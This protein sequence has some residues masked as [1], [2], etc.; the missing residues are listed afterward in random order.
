V[1]RA[2]RIRQSES[3]GA[4]A[5]P[6]P[7]GAESGWEQACAVPIV[8]VLNETIAKL[9]E[10]GF[11]EEREQFGRKAALAKLKT[12]NER[13]NETHCDSELWLKHKHRTQLSDWQSNEQMNVHVVYVCGRV[14]TRSYDPGRVWN[15][16]GIAVLARVN[17][18]WRFGYES[19]QLVSK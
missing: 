8:S 2:L 17:G 1:R 13:E 19:S 7:K 9:S 4:R 5:L 18:R 12:N 16:S 3:G 15:V 11:L 10:T 14:A 6:D